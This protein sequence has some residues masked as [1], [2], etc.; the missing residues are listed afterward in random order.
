M[1][2]PQQIAVLVHQI[3]QA[4]VLNHIADNLA[5][6]ALPVPIAL[7]HENV[8]GA[9]DVQ[10]PFEIVQLFHQVD[11]PAAA[12]DIV[13]A[14]HAAGQVQ[15]PGMLAECHHPASGCQGGNDFRYAGLR[16]ALL[17]RFPVIVPSGMDQGNRRESHSARPAGTA[18]GKKSGRG[19]RS[20][21]ARQ[22]AL[23]I[24]LSPMA[25][26]DPGHAGD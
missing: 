21:K 6:P 11:V 9:G 2:A 25:L 18:G 1:D 13:V 24:G 20:Q 26:P 7:F 4:F 17:Y 10:I 14:L 5:R 16:L 8:L 19:Q 23:Q 22:I 12:G 3:R 15:H